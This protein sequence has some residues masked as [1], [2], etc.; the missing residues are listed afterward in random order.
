MC[1]VQQRLSTACSH[2][3]SRTL[4]QTGIVLASS[5]AVDLEASSQ[6]GRGA[7]E[8]RTGRSMNTKSLLPNSDDQSR[9]MLASEAGRA[10]DNRRDGATISRN[11][12]TPGCMP[13][14]SHFARQNNPEGCIHVS[15]GNVPED[16]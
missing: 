10:T 12:L 4:P 6:D 16:H 1:R 11:Y 7:V 8:H 5:L 3:L 2:V 15:T 14:C 9:S 13:S